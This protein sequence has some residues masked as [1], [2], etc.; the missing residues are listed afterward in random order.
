[1]LNSKVIES[2][3]IKL[4]LSLWTKPHGVALCTVTNWTHRSLGNSW[5]N[6][7][8]CFMHCNLFLLQSKILHRR[9]FTL[10]FLCTL[11]AEDN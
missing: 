4:L 1:M 6:W 7:P 10:V 5:A 11:S 9:S 8:I 3:L 2:V